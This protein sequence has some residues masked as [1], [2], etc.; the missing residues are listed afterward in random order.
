M[1]DGY[2]RRRKE[3]HH[4]IRTLPEVEP[5]LVLKPIHQESLDTDSECVIDVLVQEDEFIV[6]ST[7]KWLLE[8]YVL[9]KSVSVSELNPDSMS[10]ISDDASMPTHC[11]KALWRAIPREGDDDEVLSSATFIA[12]DVICCITPT[13]VSTWYVRSGEHLK[14]VTVRGGVHLLTA[15]CKISD[16]EFVV[17]STEGHMLFFNHNRG[18]DLHETKRVRKAHY[19]K[20]MSMAVHKD[21]IVSTSADWSARV[22][23]VA[24]KERFAIFKSCDNVVGV[25]LSDEYIVTCSYSESDTGELRIYRNEGGYE[26]LKILHLR[27]WVRKPKILS[28]GFILCRLF[29]S[30]HDG[31]VPGNH[32]CVVDFHG[33]RVLAKLKFGC[34]K[35]NDYEVLPDGRIIAVGLDGWFAVI[36]TL[37]YRLR[38]LVASKRMNK[39]T[40][41]RTQ[42]NCLLM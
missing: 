40:N 10:E 2:K 16:T 34:R 8:V 36:A 20:I 6:M 7:D 14:S 19:D 17:G 32:L 39:D 41:D 30:F 27:T 11:R 37:P 4:L 13:D 12:P 15:I 42:R 29:P 22:W 28:G 38:K 3:E 26:L 1:K 23:D 24:T 5:N 21:V 25:A 9:D 35:V 18:Y 31:T 33:E